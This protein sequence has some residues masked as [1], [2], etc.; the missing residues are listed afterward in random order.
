MATLNTAKTRLGIGG[1]A[2]NYTRPFTPKSPTIP[3]VVFKG[4]GIIL[5]RVADV[6]IKLGAAITIEV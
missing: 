6:A 1:P 2:I 5:K 4:V 3:A